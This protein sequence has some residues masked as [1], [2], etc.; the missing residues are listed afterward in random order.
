MKEDFTKFAISEKGVNPNGL[1]QYGQFISS[2]VPP[3]VVE[4]RKLNT[5]TTD[6]FSRLMS[7]RIIF[8]G[9]EINDDVANIIQAQLLY[10]SSI[11]PESDISIYINSPG[12]YISAGLTIYDTMQIVTPDISVTCTGMAAS[13]AAIILCAGEKG[14]RYALPHSRIMIHQ[15]LGGAVGQAS[16]VLIAAREIEKC[17]EE[18]TEIISNHTGQSYKKVFKDTDRN[19]WMTAEDALEYGIIDNILKKK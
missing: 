1:D 7:D 8:L 16:D 15:P 4:E 17:R 11:D 3:A 14:K 10:L 18:L 19:Y 2:I 5:A 9:T 6:I 13:M 12:G